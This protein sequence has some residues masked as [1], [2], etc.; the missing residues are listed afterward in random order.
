MFDDRS[1]VV[2]ETRET[3]RK[4]LVCDLS[5]CGGCLFSSS[6]PPSHHI[7]LPVR[8]YPLLSIVIP[9]SHVNHEDIKEQITT[10]NDITKYELIIFHFY[11]IHTSQPT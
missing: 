5:K 7:V 9:F 8:S 3:A 4:K 10:R 1:N 11:Y 6:L 2:N